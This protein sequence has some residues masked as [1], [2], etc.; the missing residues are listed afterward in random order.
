MLSSLPPLFPHDV[1]PLSFLFPD[2]HLS[3]LTSISVSLPPS[4]SPLANLQT[5]TAVPSLP[6]L[7]LTQPVS[8]FYL[9][10]LAQPRSP[11]PSWPCGGG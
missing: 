8:R 9:L 6:S 10:Q 4:L 5:K 3:S 11:K 2:I 7:A 1:S